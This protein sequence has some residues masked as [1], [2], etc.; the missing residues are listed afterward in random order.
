MTQRRC[1]VV[2]GLHCVINHR[3]RC[4][5]SGGGAGRRRVGAVGAVAHLWERSC[6]IYT[7]VSPLPMDLEAFFPISCAAINAKA[8][9]R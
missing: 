8:H 5:G 1:L 2:K 7:L 3:M 4:G 9:L 6:V